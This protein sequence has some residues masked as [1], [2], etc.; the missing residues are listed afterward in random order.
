MSK[1][2]SKGCEYSNGNLWFEQQDAIITLGITSFAV[3]AL[4]SVES[5]HLPDEGEVFLKGEVVATIE[6]N[7]SSLEM[8]TPAAG[9]VEAVNRI[10]TEEPDRVIEDPLE[11]GWLLKFKIKNEEELAPFAL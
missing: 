11:E 7:R 6:G 1:S 5:I 2:T 10:L 8:V 9:V 4:G 3:N